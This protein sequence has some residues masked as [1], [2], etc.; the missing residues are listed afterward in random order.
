MSVD[1]PPER[2]RSRPA[3]IAGLVVGAVVGGIGAYLLLGGGSASYAGTFTATGSMTTPRLG[4]TATLLADG[5]V[6]IAGGASIDAGG[7][8]RTFLSSAE[9]YDPQSGTFSGTGSMTTTRAD[10]LATLLPD[11]R[12]LIAGGTSDE[13]PSF[14]ALSSA[15]LYDPSS[16][17]F[18]ATGSMTTPR[19]YATATLLPDGRVL[20]AGGTSFQAGGSSRELSSAELFDP[21]RGTFSATGSMTLGRSA[22]VATLLLD[23][24]V[25]VAGGSIVL[26]ADTGDATASA[27][28]FDPQS[29]TFSATGSM[30]RGRAAPAATLLRDGSVLIAGGWNSDAISGLSSAERF[31]PRSGTFARTGSM[32]TAGRSPTA[33]L[34]SDG[35]V[36]IVQSDGSGFVELYDPREGTFTATGAMTTPRWVPTATL[37]ADGRVLIA[38]GQ[39]SPYTVLS[40]AELFH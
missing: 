11:G 24:R 33:G 27:E 20:I 31:D 2:R 40:S 4:A 5:R 18:S 13:D 10:A 17:T 15:E 35:R 29:A 37:L 23:G 12:V 25:L 6:L 19:E 32:T 16:A 34:L 28:L 38:G 26:S 30:T 36:L 39:D 1:H 3:L 21:Q 7:T 22:A 9:L 14:P 8:S